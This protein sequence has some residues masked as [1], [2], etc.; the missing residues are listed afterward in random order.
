MTFSHDAWAVESNY[1]F[2]YNSERGLTKVL[3]SD[4]GAWDQVVAKNDSLLGLEGVSMLAISGKL[5]IRH[6]ELTDA[7]FVVYD[8]QTLEKADDA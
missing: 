3:L 5:Y 7:P 4:K 8:Q 2:N 6:K 1:L